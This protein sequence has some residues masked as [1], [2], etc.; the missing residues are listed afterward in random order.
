MMEI[1][2]ELNQTN[3]ELGL[4]VRDY[5]R[6]KG[7]LNIE[8]EDQTPS[9]IKKECLEDLFGQII[10]TLGLNPEDGNLTDTPK[11]L[12]KLYVNELFGGLDWTKFPKCTTV[13]NQFVGYNNFVLLKDIK[14]VSVCSH[15]F[16]PFFGVK[17][18]AD[19]TATFGPGC[20]IAYIP[21]NK[22]LGLSKF[23]RIVNFLVARPNTQET[24]AFLPVPLNFR[25]FLLG[26]FVFF[27]ALLYLLWR[28]Y[29]KGMTVR[30]FHICCK[31]PY[32]KRWVLPFFMKYNDKLI[33]IDHQISHLYNKRRK[34]FLKTLA[35]E[36]FA[37]V[38]NCLEVYVILLTVTSEVTLIQSVVI[39]TFMSLFTNILFFSP[40]QVGTRE[41][42]FLIAFRALSLSG[43]LGIYVSLVTRVRELFWMGVG[44]LLMK[45]HGKTSTK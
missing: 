6:S 44:I 13:D 5:L 11:R 19:G 24:F 27:T 4:K 43:G 30:F 42:G 21:K 10:Y 32:L 41:G 34:A 7:L 38:C 15:H 1:K 12:A 33:L 45:V 29:R 37:R 3:S 39:Y 20:T 2:M 8:R 31:L 35:L 14:I 25:I 26:S 16:M 36:F 18:N 17:G 28:G 40:M 22:V 23:S 9:N